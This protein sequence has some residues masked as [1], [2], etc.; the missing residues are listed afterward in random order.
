[1]RPFKISQVKTNVRG[2]RCGESHHNSGRYSDDL[3]AKVCASYVRDKLGYHQLG[4]LLGI[5]W[6]TIQKWVNGSRRKP[7]ARIQVRRV[8]ER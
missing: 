6:P 2:I 1:M 8:Y 7:A 5:P 4:N 3:V